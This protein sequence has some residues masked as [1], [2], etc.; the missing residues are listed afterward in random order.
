MDGDLGHTVAEVV[1][2]AVCSYLTPFTWINEFQNQGRFELVASLWL[3]CR[4]ARDAVDAS[5]TGIS[6]GGGG[7][8]GC[9]PVIPDPACRQCSL[10][11]QQQQAARHA[12]C[13]PVHHQK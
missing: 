8:I 1:S 11:Q 13:L 9:I 4:S 10:D 12:A 7:L 5:T 6:V 2:T 3:T